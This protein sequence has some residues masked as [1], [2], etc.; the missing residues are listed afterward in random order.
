MKRDKLVLVANLA[1]QAY[2]DIPDEGWNLISHE[3]TDGQAMVSF[4]EDGPYDVIVSFRG[5]S[6]SKDILVD[7]NVFTRTPRFAEDVD[8]RIRVHHGFAD[9]YDGLR[10]RVMECMKE[11]KRILVLGHSLGGALAT[12]CALDCALHTTSDVDC[13]SFGSPRTG[14]KTFAKYFKK[15]VET[16]VRC[17]HNRDIVTCLPLPLRFRHVTGAMNLRTRW[18]SSPVDDHMIDRYIE[19]FV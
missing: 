12:I 1:K 5:T 16:S 11:R 18:F 9:Q 10:E 14:N 13:V 2:N 19:A 4:P 8:K 7:L 15:N 3:E 6:S 17:V